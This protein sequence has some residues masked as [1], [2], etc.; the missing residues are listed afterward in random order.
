MY[1]YNQSTYYVNLIF[2]IFMKFYKDLN[3]KNEIN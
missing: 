3:Y 1:S 2:K